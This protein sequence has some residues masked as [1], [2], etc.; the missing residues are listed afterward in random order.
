MQQFL[1]LLVFILTKKE[2]RKHNWDLYLS[3]ESHVHA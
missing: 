3:A 2:I 1:F